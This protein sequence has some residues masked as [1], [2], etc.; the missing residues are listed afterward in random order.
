MTASATRARGRREG[1]E[2]ASSKACITQGRKTPKATSSPK[3][4]ISRPQRNHFPGR[5][6]VGMASVSRK[7]S[8]LHSLPEQ[9]V[10]CARRPLTRRAFGPRRPVSRSGVAVV[11]GRSLPRFKPPEAK[12]TKLTTRN[13]ATHEDRSIKLIDTELVVL[14]ARRSGRTERQRCLRAR[15]RRLSRSSPRL[16]SEKGLVREMRAKPGMPVWRRDEEG[17]SL[18]LIITKLGR[19]AIDMPQ[20]E[21]SEDAGRIPMCRLDRQ[22]SVC[23]IGA[24]CTS[25]GQQAR[26]GH[27]AA[28]PQEGRPH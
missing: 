20:E 27:L 13:S 16:W 9:C 14:W 5:K 7:S 12:M 10:V 6:P 17:R 28:W 4:S 1:S 25:A 19:A 3:A 18:A 15:R 2:R 22:R 23:S 11:T 24:R 8:G 21:R 26:R